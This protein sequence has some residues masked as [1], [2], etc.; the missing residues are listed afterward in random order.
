ML[1]MLICV[2]GVAIRVAPPS[3]D[4]STVAAAARERIRQHDTAIQGICQLLSIRQ[5]AY[6]R[7]GQGYDLAAIS[8]GPGQVNEQRMGGSSA[9][10]LNPGAQRPSG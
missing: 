7:I 8:A 10:T 2:G 1:R 4:H 5:R 9:H 3:S 6:C